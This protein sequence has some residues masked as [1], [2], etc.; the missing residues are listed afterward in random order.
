MLTHTSDLWEALVPSCHM[1][2]VIDGKHDHNTLYLLLRRN[3]VYFLNCC[4]L[5]FAQQKM[6]RVIACHNYHN[7]LTFSFRFFLWELQ[8]QWSLQ[9][10]IQQF[11]INILAKS[12]FFKVCSYASLTGPIF[13]KITS[14]TP[15]SNLTQVESMVNLIL[16]V[17]F[18]S[19]YQYFHQGKLSLVKLNFM[20]VRNVSPTE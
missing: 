4:W 2:M 15:H 10:Q 9:I 13:L 18:I 5:C 16:C 3:G 14:C 11:P 12:M 17:M 19:K 7:Y 1:A 6:A 8:Y 20:R